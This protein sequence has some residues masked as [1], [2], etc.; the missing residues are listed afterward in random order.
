MVHGQ[1]RSGN[2]THKGRNE[3]FYSQGFFIQLGIIFLCWG[4]TSGGESHRLLSSIWHL[5]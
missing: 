4:E 2:V 3:T 5:M 1:S